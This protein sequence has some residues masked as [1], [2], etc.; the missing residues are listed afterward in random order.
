[1]KTPDDQR[2]EDDALRAQG[3]IDSRAIGRWL[4]FGAADLRRSPGPGLT[5]GVVFT[6]VGWALLWVA[7]DQFWWLVGAYSG[8]LIVAPLAVTGLYEVS[9]EG[10]LGHR[11]GLFDIGLLWLR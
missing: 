3:V 2:Q 10:R 4:P 7:S 9:R 5:H 6:L 11:V 8:F 1:M